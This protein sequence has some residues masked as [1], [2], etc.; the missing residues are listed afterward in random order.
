VSGGRELPLEPDV[1]TQVTP[2]QYGSDL[3]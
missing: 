3:R 1:A 2:V